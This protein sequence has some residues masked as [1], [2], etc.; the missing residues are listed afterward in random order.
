M[1][2]SKFSSS[3]NSRVNKTC[4]TV[5]KHEVY[6]ASRL[7][8]LLVV[9]LL[10]H[11]SHLSVYWNKQLFF[12]SSLFQTENSRT[13]TSAINLFL[14]YQKSKQLDG[15]FSWIIRRRPIYFLPIFPTI[16]RTKFRPV[17]NQQ[18]QLLF[19]FFQSG[20]Q[21]RPVILSSHVFF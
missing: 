5:L 12:C 2:F 1:C 20:F 3:F 9:A 13:M 8:L 17:W 19:L 11:L 18:Q 10:S 21:I 14:Y 7:L 15:E 4:R 6:Y 16:L